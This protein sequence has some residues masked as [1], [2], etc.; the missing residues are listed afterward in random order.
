[1]N[2]RPARIVPLAYA[3]MIALGALALMLPQATAEGR[4]APF[5][6]AL[7][8]S[9]SAI[10]VTGLAVVDTAAYWSPFGHAIIFALFQIGGFG[11]M[12]GAALLAILVARRLNLSTQLMV[13]REAAASRWET[14]PACCASRSPASSSCNF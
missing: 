6:V 13:Q 4:S 3:V 8:T 9:T 10:T 5:L 1:V 12:S 14:S 2:A 7:F 11:V